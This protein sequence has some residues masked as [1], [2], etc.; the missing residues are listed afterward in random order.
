M[1]AVVN[2]GVCRDLLRL[3]DNLRN[4]IVRGKARGIALCIR[5]DEGGE[6][7]VFAGDYRHDPEAALRAAMAISWEITKKSGAP[8][9]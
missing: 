2:L 8:S 3:S 7:V 9:P 5:D 1:T 6:T 4:S